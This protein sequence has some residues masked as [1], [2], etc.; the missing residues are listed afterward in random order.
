MEFSQQRGL[1]GLSIG[2]CVL[3]PPSPVGKE[4]HGQLLCLLCSFGHICRVLVMTF[5]SLWHTYLHPMMF[6]LK[7]KAEG[8]LAPENRPLQQ[9]AAMTRPIAFVLISRSFI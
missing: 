7:H 3:A 2:T 9:V 4:Q 8:A 5:P 6:P 1:N